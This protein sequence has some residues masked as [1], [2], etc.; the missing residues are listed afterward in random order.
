MNKRFKRL[1]R[2]GLMKMVLLGLPFIL[3]AAGL[4]YAGG[5]MVILT[6]EDHG[7]T[8]E[9][10]VSSEFRVELLGIPTTGFLWHIAALDQEYLVLLGQ[11]RKPQDSAERKEGAAAITIFRL[12][13]V[14]AGK[15]ELKAAYYRP[16]EGG[17]K[18]LDRLEVTLE[19]KSE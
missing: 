12:K 18:S 2:H 9:V 4:V 6:R 14:K 16:W 17:D 7:K 11:D 5:D 15:T 13:A 19:I 10:P 3:S 1:P 8:I